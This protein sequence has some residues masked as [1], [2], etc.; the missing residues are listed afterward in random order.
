MRKE[1]EASR[2]LYQYACQG[3]KRCWA[4]I[5]VSSYRYVVSGARIIWYYKD[6]R[7]APPNVG[8]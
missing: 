6:C 5:K 4:K 3:F 7:D 2:I 1:A 8:R